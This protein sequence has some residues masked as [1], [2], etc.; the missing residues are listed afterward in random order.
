[1]AW[2]G[3][4]DLPGQWKSWLPRWLTSL[5]VGAA[6]CGVSLLIRM[7]LQLVWPTIVPFGVMFPMIL[8]ATLIGRLLGGLTCF[9]LGGLVIWFLIRPDLLSG[10]FAPAASPAVFILYILTGGT[11]LLIAEAYRRDHNALLREQA[12]RAQAE[13]EHQRLLAQELNHR[14]KNLL[15]TVQAIASQTLKGPGTDEAARKAFE[16]RLVALARVHDLLTAGEGGGVPLDRLVSAA[17][18]PFEDGHTFQIDGSALLLPPR[19]A[20]AFALALHELATNALKYGA[21]SSPEGH[22]QIGWQRE[23]AGFRL[24]WLE[25]GGPPVAA[26]DREGFGTRLLKRN[27]AAEISGEIVIDYAPDGVRCEILAPHLSS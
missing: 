25:R 14:I 17:I 7:A 8:L 12:L 16:D 23:G 13:T 22:V 6:L 1:L 27:L 20:V 26:P 9:L 3:R 24:R 19:Q 15:V 5:L 18:A 11:L 2:V 4:L 21:L 10:G